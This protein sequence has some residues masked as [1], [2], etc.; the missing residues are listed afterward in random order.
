[1][2][3]EGEAAA[4]DE[5]DEGAGAFVFGVSP[6]VE[7]GEVGLDE[8]DDLDGP[9]AYSFP[10]ESPEYELAEASDEG[11]DAESAVPEGIAFGRDEEPGAVA[12]A[13][14]GAPATGAPAGADT[15]T[16]A[17]ESAAAEHAGDEEILLLRETEAVDEPEAPEPAVEPWDPSVALA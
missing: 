17:V 8:Q 5:L 11:G 4:G 9:D 14:F 10:P 15:D 1:P 13:E 2:E 6:A 12:A 16:D 7:H 3:A